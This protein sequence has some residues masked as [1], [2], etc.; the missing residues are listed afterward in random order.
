MQDGYDQAGGF[1]PGLAAL[2]AS[3]VTGGVGAYGYSKAD[4][5]KQ[6]AAIQA[7]LGADWKEQIESSKKI[8]SEKQIDEKRIKDLEATV[9][10][11]T[12]KNKEIAASA[13]ASS[14]P[15]LAFKSATPEVLTAAADILLQ[16]M[17][18]KYP[19]VSNAPML[20]AALLYP[21]T[22]QGRLARMSLPDF[23]EKRIKP[24]AQQDYEAAPKGGRMRRR[25]ARRGGVT[26]AQRDA[27]D[28]N[29]PNFTAE[30]KER[31]EQFLNED[32]A[33]AAAVAAPAAPAAP[34]AAP[35]AP[36]F[37]FPS[38]EEFSQLYAAAITSA[39]QSAAKGVVSAR[40]AEEARSKAARDA[41]D[42]KVQTKKNQAAKKAAGLL[43]E[44]LDKAVQRGTTDLASI[45]TQGLEAQKAD[46]D[47]LLADA[48]AKTDSLRA[49]ET[50][51]G[52]KSIEIQSKALLESL[53]AAV[54][55]YIEAA[56]AVGPVPPPGMGVPPGPPPLP[57][58]PQA[59]QSTALH[60]ALLVDTEALLKKMAGLIKEVDAMK[61]GLNSAL[62]QL[63][64]PEQYKGGCAVKVIADEFTDILNKLS[65]L[66]T[67]RTA[68][69]KTSFDAYKK[70]TKR[71][72]IYDT[73]FRPNTA[74][75]AESKAAIDTAV[76]ELT[77][78]IE[79]FFA[80]VERTKRMRGGDPLGRINTL[81]D[82]IELGTYALNRYSTNILGLKGSYDTMLDWIDTVKETRLETPAE[83]EAEKKSCPG[84]I[85]V[86]RTELK[87]K[88][89]VP[90]AVLSSLSEFAGPRPRR[91]SKGKSSR[92]AP[93]ATP[94]PTASNP[95]SAANSGPPSPVAPVTP[96]APVATVGETGQTVA[97]LVSNPVLPGQVLPGN[98]ALGQSLRNLVSPP[99]KGLNV[100]TTPSATVTVGTKPRGLKVRK[101][102]QSVT[103]RTN[104]GGNAR[105]ST[106]KKRRG[107]K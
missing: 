74:K 25:R 64:M 44:K 8:Q 53:P 32:E 61:T 101:P 52:W 18:A 3:L 36:G 67:R 38:Y 72:P 33:P 17:A 86:L 60:D 22:Y 76:N 34:V 15:A 47:R 45:R 96:V 29:L 62:K 27:L 73:S 79:T 19:W 63:P 50:E 93:L 89:G 9:A 6:E 31:T 28:A 55:A 92:S 49:V 75:L 65:P 59:P 2:I 70:E 39:Q 12:A 98:A 13:A 83:W 99:K 81:R 26:E 5:A 24:S 11:L 20:K 35:T 57:S 16:S 41:V 14:G 77:A 106:L 37:P 88:Q 90:D 48:T 23:Y 102:G 4:G 80:T 82:E 40:A 91:R 78:R 51:E 107:G 104:T 66:I 54:K 30:D 58:A 87:K 69:L 21:T 95:G 105:K 56:K 7:A 100:R 1:D 42:A 84:Q 10:A 85:E 46:V 71:T 43:A 103:V 68:S 97:Q 94:S